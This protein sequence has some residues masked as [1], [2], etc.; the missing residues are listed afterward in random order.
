M[1]I[2]GDSKKS[3]AELN[4]QM[5]QMEQQ[6]GE[7]AQDYFRPG[8]SNQLVF[9]RAN[10]TIVGKAAFLDGLKNNPFQQRHSEDVSVSVQED[11]ALVTLIVVG[12]R[13]D[14]GSV[15]RYRNIRLFS[16]SGEQWILE[17]WYNYEITGL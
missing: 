17:F 8:L 12:Q 16:R 15:H 6:G 11:R 10:G 7:A 4:Q 9:R 5:L 1:A 13:K 3:L 14:D 2:N